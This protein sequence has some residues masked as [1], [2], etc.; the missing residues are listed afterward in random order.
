[1]NIDRI[2][3]FLSKVPDY[4][5][6]PELVQT[7]LEDEEFLSLLIEFQEN[8]FLNTDIIPFVKASSELI[9]DDFIYIA[10]GDAPSKFVDFQRWLNP[11]TLCIV[12]FPLSDLTS[13]GGET[14]E[15]LTIYLFQF[16]F[17]AFQ[18]IDKADLKNLCYMD[19][20]MTGT[21]KKCIEQAISAIYQVEFTF[22]H[23]YDLKDNLS[24]ESIR[25]AENTLS[26]CM[27]EYPM[28][29]P[30]DR[31]IYRRGHH[32][33]KGH[34]IFM[35]LSVFYYT[36]MEKYRALT[37]QYPINSVILT[38]SQEKKSNKGDVTYIDDNYEIVTLKDVTIRDDCENLII[39]GKMVYST[40]IVHLS[41]T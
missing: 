14:Q 12:D 37:A 5:M 27:V 41:L 15:I 22:P 29:K 4:R 3:T 19:Y 30:L 1:M 35:F 23:V 34:N 38:T 33:I 7:H 26:R 24:L 20:I 6:D 39:D 32:Q 36:N 40:Q 11:S 18:R 25:S 21:K 9:R 16:F 13:V 2:K 8:H 17:T 10:P 28:S 31:V